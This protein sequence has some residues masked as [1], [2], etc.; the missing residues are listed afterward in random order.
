MCYDHISTTL[1][2]F[3]ALIV[4]FEQC[5]LAPHSRIKEEM[6]KI[7]IYDLN[8]PPQGCQHAYFTCF[9][10]LQS[11]KDS[12]DS[13]RLNHNMLFSCCFDCIFYVTC[14]S[15][16]NLY[17]SLWSPSKEIIGFSVKYRTCRLYQHNHSQRANSQLKGS[18]TM[19]SHC[20]L[21]HPRIS[22]YLCLRVRPDVA[23]GVNCSNPIV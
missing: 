10:C 12:S 9:F 5:H 23:L 7:T 21:F 8:Q 1:M 19:T 13:V 3:P 18:G 11:K 4:P 20:L 2:T 6:L 15:L 22:G 17:V 16:Y 14:N